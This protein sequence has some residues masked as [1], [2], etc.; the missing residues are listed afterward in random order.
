MG[1][2][3]CVGVSFALV[4]YVLLH[5][6]E[7]RGGGVYSF[8]ASRLAGMSYTLYLTHLPVLVFICAALLTGERWQPSADR[9][10]VVGLILLVVFLYSFAI[11]TVTE[12]KT[13]VYRH[14]VEM[15]FAR[16]A[17]LAALGNRKHA[18]AAVV[19]GEDAK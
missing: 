17:W 19:V 8:I 3:Y 13:N 18:P 14:F 4:V 1:A 6:P 5:S 15:A 11:S 12:A 7:R 10:T 9:L 16:A 2:D